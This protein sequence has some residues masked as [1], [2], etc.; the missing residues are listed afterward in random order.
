ML[1]WRDKV[2]EDLREIREK[3]E[4]LDKKKWRTR[5]HGIDAD[6]K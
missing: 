4:A 1:S 3:E 2:K 6:L 5:L